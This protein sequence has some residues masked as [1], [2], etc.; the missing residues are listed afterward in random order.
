MGKLVTAALLGLALFT[1]HPQGVQANAGEQ[2]ARAS[3]SC[4]VCYGCYCC[5]SAA[6]DAACYLEDCGYDTLIVYQGGYYC[7]YYC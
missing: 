1:G 3:A 7:V 5:Y 4:W 6:Y 2:Q